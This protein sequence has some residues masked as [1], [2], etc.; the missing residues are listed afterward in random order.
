MNRI[1]EYSAGASM[2]RKWFDIDVQAPIRWV[3]QDHYSTY[4][5]S[6]VADDRWSNPNYP[7]QAMIWHWE[8]RRWWALEEES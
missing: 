3:P 8:E 7:N 2:A 4:F 1:L 6:L 5:D